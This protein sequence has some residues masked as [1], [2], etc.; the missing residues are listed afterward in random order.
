MT[1]EETLAEWIPSQRWFAG[2]GA[3]ILDVAIVADTELAS[4]DPGLRHL[5]VAV[6]QTRGSQTVAATQAI[7]KITDERC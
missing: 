5:I 4:G 1:F 2:K 3:R 6:S 7:L